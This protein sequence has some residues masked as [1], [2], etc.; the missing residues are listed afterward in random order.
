MEVGLQRGLQNCPLPTLGHW[1][2]P[3][4]PSRMGPLQCGLYEPETWETGGLGSQT[5]LTVPDCMTWA[6]QCLCTSV[7]SFVKNGHTT[8]TPG[9]WREPDELGTRVCRV[10]GL[11]TS[12]DP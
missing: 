7:S 5:A 4:H 9:L 6:C 10:T 8:S 2:I 3:R 1:A 11:G 12:A